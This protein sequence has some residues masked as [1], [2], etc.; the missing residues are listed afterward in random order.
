MFNTNVEQAISICRTNLTNTNKQV[1]HVWYSAWKGCSS[2]YN[3]VVY[4]LL[5]APEN[6]FEYYYQS[7]Y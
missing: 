4:Y 1:F 3:I 7:L 2:V 5:T 6:M